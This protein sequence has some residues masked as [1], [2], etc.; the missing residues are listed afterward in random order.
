VVDHHV[1]GEACLRGALSGEPGNE[2]CGSRASRETCE[3]DEHQDD[4]IPALKRGTV[5]VGRRFDAGYSTT[6]IRAA[7]A[8]ALRR[9]RA[10][11]L[12]YA[13]GEQLPFEA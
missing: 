7:G 2:Q 3:Q 1:A 13:L 9:L 8:L 10:F 5:F 12:L 11:Y 4:D 6:C